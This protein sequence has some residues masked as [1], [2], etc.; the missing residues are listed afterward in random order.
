MLFHRPCGQCKFHGNNVRRII[1]HIREFSQHSFVF[2]DV[3]ERRHAKRFVPYKGSKVGLV[4]QRETVLS[5]LQ[6]H[7]LSWLVRNITVPRLV[8]VYFLMSV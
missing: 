1:S 4:F 7:K 2:F 6:D 3:L 8:E 5:A